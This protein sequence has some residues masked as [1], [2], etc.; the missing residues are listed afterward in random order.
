M[1]HVANIISAAGAGP[2]AFLALGLL[3]LTYISTRWF[4]SERTALRVTV[5]VSIFLLICA[6]PI[7]LWLSDRYDRPSR[8]SQPRK[9]T[10]TDDAPNEKPRID[11]NKNSSPAAA[12]TAASPTRR[13]EHPGH[14]GDKSTFVEESEPVRFNISR[15]EAA[16]RAKVFTIYFPL[17]ISDL[18]PSETAF[19]DNVADEFTRSGASQVLVQG[20]TDRWGSSSYNVGVSQRFADSVKAYLTS[21]GVPD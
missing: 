2:L 6:A 14:S 18:T 21:R 10:P 17:D 5:F 20:H 19:L 8:Q 4:G 11:L 7:L 13:D 9:E 12:P 3:V 15:F 16:L 1:Q